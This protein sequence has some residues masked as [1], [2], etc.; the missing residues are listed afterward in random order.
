MQ[1]R[2]APPE[3]AISI[4]F[5]G[6]EIRCRPGL[7]LAAALTQAG[8]L[9]LRDAGSGGA[10][11]L[12]CGMGVCQ[13]CRVDL[14]DRQ[15]VRACMCLAEDGQRLSRHRRFR[16]RNAQGFHVGGNGDCQPWA[17]DILVIGAGPGG[18]AA[19]ALAAEAGADVVL[20]DDRTHP[21]GQFYKQPASPRHVPASLAGDPQFA[22]GRALI[23]R[24]ERSGAKRLAATEIW[25]AFP[26][27]EFAA[28][29][30]DGS[31][32]FKPKRTIVATGAFERGL[33]LPGWTLPG[34]MTTGAAQT[35]LRAHGVLPGRRV[36]VAGNGPLN[37]QVALELKRAGAQV[38]AVA[39]LSAAPGPAALGQAW[40]M[41]RNAPGLTFKGLA[42]LAGLRWAGVPV[43][44]QRILTAVEKGVAGLIA[45]LGRIG[46]EGPTKE[47]RFEVDAVCMGYGFQPSNELLKCL[48]CRHRYDER[49]GQL[50]VARSADCETSLPGIYAIGDCCGLGGAPAA[51]REGILAATAAVRSLGLDLAPRMLAERRV[52][53]RELRRQRAFQSA[54]WQLFAAPRLQTELA[55]PDTP[56][57]RCENV[58]LGDIEEALNRGDASIG[59]LKRRTRLGMGL[60]QGRYCA[61]LAAAMIARRTGHPLDE[62]SFFAPRIPL[63]PIAIGRLAQPK[64]A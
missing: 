52:A 18:L 31:C 56:I 7:S 17:P 41:L 57:C 1:S 14:D 11:G 4:F 50:V 55:E 34:A 2:R 25:G 19:A 61:P 27:N 21:G 44:H 15:G 49:F 45:W 37:L 3:D 13:E 60:C 24:A 53:L 63:R 26:P 20:V 9:R 40:R 6:R 48:G 54:L 46:P 47:V 12:F 35:L 29:H 36:L 62:F 8:E 51:I 16:P 38:A 42:C 5:E 59:M 64:F 43:L 22:A 32:M 23:E 30:L 10:R 39:E 58:C 28:A 33:P